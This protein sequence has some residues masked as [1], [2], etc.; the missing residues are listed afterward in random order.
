MS[1]RLRPRDLAFLADE[2]PTTPDAQRDAWR[3][4]SPATRASTTPALV[5]LIADRIAF[6]PRYRQR[7]QPVPGRLAN[8]VW[9]DDAGFDL[10]Y[11]VRRSALPAP[12]H[13][14]PAARAG[15]PHRVPAARPQP[16]AVGDATS[17]RGS[18]AA[19]SR[20]CP[21]PTRS[22]STASRPSTSAR[23][24]STCRPEPK[25]LAPRRV[26]P[27][28]AGRRR[29]RSWPTPSTESLAHPSTH[30]QHGAQQR[31]R[32]APAVG[33]PRPRRVGRRRR[34][35]SPNRRPVSDSPVTGEL[36][37]Q[38]RF[39]TRPHRPRRLPQ[40][41]PGARRHGQRR[42]PGHHRRRAARLAAGPVR[43]DGGRAPA[44]RDGADVG[45][46]RRARGDL[47]R[48]PD[49]PPLVDLPIGEASP[50]VRLHQVSYAFQAHKDTGRAVA[51]N[52]LAGI[53]GF[54]P[55]TFHALGSRVAAAEARKGFHLSVTN[56]PGPQFPLYAAGAQM[57]ETY[58]VHPLLPGHALAIG[59]TSYDGG[60]LLRHHRRPGPAARRR[61]PRPVHHRGARG[62]RRDRPRRP[63]P[64]GPRSQ[65]R[66]E[67]AE[68]TV[69][70]G[71]TSRRPWP[72]CAAGR[73][74]ASCPAPPTPWSRRTTTRRR[75]TPRC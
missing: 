5:R 30:R 62:A 50:V 67:E 47:A 56:V 75:S 43:V 27:A 40:D 42:R 57:V 59:V 39:V 10:A 37:Q 22:W 41:P 58:P 14:G 7:L 25:Q 21:S 15:R 72:G 3:S 64:S 66:R 28:S 70:G 46:R 61:P 60:R 32:G 16:A 35:R 73:G 65:A 11:H 38:R 63:P 29:R 2:S 20:C 17:S 24:C 55:T 19:G 68:G 33:R 36:S 31:V 12:G 8:P 4:S 53:A 51:A 74:R 44:A 48:Q 23:C 6:V 9:V 71:S 1:D 13:Q 69:T 18:R 54:A 26:A 49:H 45:H 52:R 34:R